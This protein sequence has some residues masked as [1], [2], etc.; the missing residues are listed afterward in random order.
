MQTRFP[1]TNEAA[2]A[3]LERS[4]G[5]DSLP[6]CY[7]EFLLTHNGGQPKEGEFKVEGWGV[8]VI[9]E[10]FGLSTRTKSAEISGNIAALEDVLPDGVIPIGCDP[11]GNMICLDV[12]G[13]SFGRLY[14]L[15]ASSKL[16]QLV[17]VAPDLKSFFASLKPSGTFG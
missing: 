2:V 11:G 5:V 7:R 14:L 4:L 9:Q 10:F 15:D 1:P 3:A 6:S 12:T 16:D 13:P 8:T 17:P